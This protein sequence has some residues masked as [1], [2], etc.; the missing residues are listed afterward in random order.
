M[1]PPVRV[2]LSGTRTATEASLYLFLVLYFSA[3]AKN[4]L[5]VRVPRGAE[6]HG[7]GIATQGVANVCMK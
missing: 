2:L 5:S 3:A 4:V 1:Q 7:Q 6:Q